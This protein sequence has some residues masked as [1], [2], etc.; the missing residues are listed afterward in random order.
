MGRM[1]GRT[2]ET[3]WNQRRYDRRTYTSQDERNRAS[4]V[5]GE[6]P[7]DYIYVGDKCFFYNGKVH[8]VILPSS[9]KVIGKHAF[10]GCQFQK[11]V[12]FPPSLEEIKR[13]AFAGNRRLRKVL[14]PATVKN[15]GAECYRECS[16]LRTVEFDKKSKCKVIPRGIFDSCIKLEKVSLPDAAK[17]ID[18]RAFYRCKELKNIDLPDSVEEIRDEAFYFCGLETLD[19]PVNLK[20]IGDSAFF[21]CKNLRTVYIPETVKTIGR[22]AFHGCSRLERIEIF[23]DPEEIGPWV[24]NKSCTIVCRKDSK[25]DAYGKEY[26]FQ[27]EY[28]DFPEE[29]NG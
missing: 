14:F 20:V 2:E 8:G 19:L 28:V 27:R 3:G 16:S 6:V 9:C 29:V 24:I 1:T 11:T 17:I 13:R 4:G 26:G 22:W 7:E 12:V 21:R 15:L 10:E 5:P 25:I 18:K 23:H